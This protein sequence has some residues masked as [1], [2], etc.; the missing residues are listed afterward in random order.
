MPTT[1][2]SQVPDAQLDHIFGLLESN[3]DFIPNV[4]ERKA[5]VA[6]YFRRRSGAKPKPAAPAT[7]VD[8]NLEAAATPVA[9]DPSMMPRAPRGFLAKSDEEI[10]APLSPEAGGGMGVTVA[11]LPAYG[12]R[13]YQALRNQG[14]AAM[15]AGAARRAV[16]YQDPEQIE[17]N[18]ATGLSPEEAGGQVAQPQDAGDADRTYYDSVTGGMPGA[19]GRVVDGVFVPGRLDALGRV[20][21]TLGDER[22]AKEA[23]NEKRLAAMFSKQAQD[24]LNTY[25]TRQMVQYQYDDK[26]NIIGTEYV[27]PSLLTDEEAAQQRNLMSRRGME[28]R[29]ARQNA[30]L[31]ARTG[32]RTD[33]Q[34][35]ASRDFIRRRAMLAGGAENITSA[36]RGMWN[37]LTMLPPEEQIRQLT[38][39]LPGGQLVA[40]VEARQLDQAAALAQRGI[41]GAL[42]GTAAG[43]L[44]DRQA[45]ALGLQNNATRAEQ[46]AG[47]EA[48]IAEQYAPTGMFGYDEFTIQEQ[49]DAIDT[50]VN[51]HRY[52][53]PEAQAAVDAMAS[54]RRAT[55]R[56]PRAGQAAPAGS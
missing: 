55:Q 44:A 14:R 17:Y 40:G 21:T 28:A 6:E 56:L 8:A 4:D 54:K 13:Y 38:Y 51:V 41:Q 30:A 52:T 26:D 39:A 33:A 43:P 2:F 36:N 24:D 15:E 46:R 7:N 5:F 35:A 16:G 48:G 18:R 3:P 23:A 31:R 19:V 49:Q 1:D 42:A 53:L 47:I 9:L 45:E 20:M 25:G 11:D 27:P 12:E 50:L 10:L 37:Q 29:Q 34:Q 32:G 22:R